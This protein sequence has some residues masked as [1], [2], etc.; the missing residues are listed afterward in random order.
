M[1]AKGLKKL[2][3]GHGV[4]RLAAPFYSAKYK[5]RASGSPEEAMALRHETFPDIGSSCH[6]P[7][8]QRSWILSS[9]PIM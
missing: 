1:V 5:Q 4:Y 2:G 9:R 3:L 7:R 8:R 6:I